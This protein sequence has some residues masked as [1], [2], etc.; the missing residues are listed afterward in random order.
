MIQNI[1]KL[2]EYLEHAQ[3]KGAFTLTQ[4]ADIVKTV[5]EIKAQLQQQ[6]QQQKSQPQR[7]DTI[8]EEDEKDD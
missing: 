5:D 8:T 2:I 4:A 1:Q 6:S 3:Q 7:L